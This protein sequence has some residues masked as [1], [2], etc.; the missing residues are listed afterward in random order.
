MYTNRSESKT[1]AQ[2]SSLGKVMAFNGAT[3]ELNNSDHYVIRSNDSKVYNGSI[4]LFA[5]VLRPPRFFSFK[6]M[7][8]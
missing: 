7:F 5:C 1:A 2:S 3:L 4:V 8:Q 6:E